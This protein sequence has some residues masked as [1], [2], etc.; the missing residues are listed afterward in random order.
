MLLPRLAVLAEIAWSTEK[1]RNFKSL[2][3][4]LETAKQR[5][6]A[7]QI[8]YRKG[9]KL[10]K[11]AEVSAENGALPGSKHDITELLHGPGTYLLRIS[12]KNRKSPAK[13]AEIRITAGEKIVI[14]VKKTAVNGFRRKWPRW[15]SDYIIR[16]DSYNQKTKYHL[17]ILPGT[18]TG[19]Y[20]VE[21]AEVQPEGFG[22]IL[23]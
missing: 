11:L 19:T 22:E 1:Q 12:Q 17:E 10:A 14:S 2:L 13:P 3:N 7:M 23:K 21:F 8:Y 5:Y 4:R 9:Y 15:I 18:G 16:L 20:S 6:Q